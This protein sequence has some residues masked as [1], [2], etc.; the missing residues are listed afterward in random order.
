MFRYARRNWFGVLF[1]R[2]GSSSPGVT[3]RV[4]VFGGIGVVALW[5]EREGIRVAL[6]VGPFELAGAVL[7][8]ML[9]FRTNTA[10]NRFWEGRT[11]W[12][13][14]VNACRNLSRVVRY[15]ASHEEARARDFSVWVVV[16]A[17]ATRYRLRGEDAWPE[18]ER[19]LP[20]ASFAALREA[21]HPSLHAAGEMSARLAALLAGAAI[22]PMLAAKAEQAVIELV[23]KLGGCERILKTPTPL[24]YVLLLRRMIALYLALLPLALLSRLGYFT[25]LVTVLVA[26]PVLMIE[27]LSSEL[28]EPFGHDANDL[29]LTRITE[30]IE[31]DVLPVALQKTV[32]PERLSVLVAPED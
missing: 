9:A 15:Y 16:F 4:L 30:T 3:L 2:S 32:L 28:D 22:D 14:I 23:D 8:L 26:Y 11:L 17:H 24:G 12:G 1:S 7:G 19:L 29:P 6:P 18:I 13:G 31:R 25:P 27:A 10:Y 20:P 21:H 5:L